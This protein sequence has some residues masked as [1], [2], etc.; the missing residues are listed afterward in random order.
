[1][2]TW[3]LEP[4]TALL[5]RFL[6]RMTGLFPKKESQGTNHCI[7]KHW[8]NKWVL[9]LYGHKC[10]HTQTQH[11]HT[12]PEGQPFFFFFFAPILHFFH[13][14]IHVKHSLWARHWHHAP[15]IQRLQMIT[16]VNMTQKVRQIAFAWLRHCHYLTCHAYYY[17]LKRKLNLWSLPPNLHLPQASPS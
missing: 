13:H 4:T 6:M 9:I 11:T 12:H 14:Q 7:L 10:L 16:C 2:I 5:S 15:V 8:L 17:H 1:M 3:V